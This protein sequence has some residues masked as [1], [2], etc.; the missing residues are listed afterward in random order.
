MAR[1][2][3]F[4]ALIPSLESHL[5]ADAAGAA[6]NAPPRASSVRPLLDRVDPTAELGRWREAGSLLRDARPALYLAEVHNPEGVLGAPP[7]RFLLCAL[8]PDAAEPLESEPYRPRSAQVEPTVTLAAD[9]HG[10]LKGLLAEAAERG[11]VVWQGTFQGAPMSLR[12][13][14]PSPVARRIQAVLDDAP[15]RPLAELDARR[16]SLAAVVPLSDPGLHFEPVHRAIKGVSTFQE[17]TFLRLVTAYARV[18]ELDEPLTSARG[19]TLARERLATLVRGQ[20]AVLLV[21]P[22]GRGKILRFR[23]GLDLAHL[24][25]APRNPTLR[26]L[27]LALLNALVL[28]TVMGIQEPEAPGHPQVFAIQGLDALVRDVQAGTFQVGFALNPP[29]LWEVRAVMEAAQSLPPKTLRVEPAPPAG[30]LFL[31][32]EA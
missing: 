28:R 7:V 21:L 24:K 9:D 20:H 15:L 17:D 29:P 1:V 19:V 31:D 25:A 8:A 6:F 13:I 3:P 30:L 16:P 2:L 11:S 18:Y 22:E 14:E 26:S 12:R 10:V 27:D 23:Q 32:P 5:S 4:S